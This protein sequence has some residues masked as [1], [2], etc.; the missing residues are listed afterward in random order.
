VTPSDLDVLVVVEGA[1]D[2]VLRTVSECAWGNQL[3]TGIMLSRLCVAT[4]MGERS[5]RIPLL[6]LQFGERSR[7][8]NPQNV[9]V[10]VHIVWSRR[11]PHWTTPNVSLMP[12]ARPQSS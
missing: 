9:L 4:G 7:R 1:R 2:D 8:M 10:L 12:T 6:A 5:A 11:Q 3:A